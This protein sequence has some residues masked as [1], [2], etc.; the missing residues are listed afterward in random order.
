M[1]QQRRYDNENLTVAHTIIDLEKRSRTIGFPLAYREALLQDHDS[2][3][4]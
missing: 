2:R 3:L 1:T 4:T